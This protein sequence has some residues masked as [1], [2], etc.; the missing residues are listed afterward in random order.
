MKNRLPYA[1]RPTVQ[2]GV[3]SGGFVPS[4]ATEYLWLRERTSIKLN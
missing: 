3:G 2:G 4:P 1:V